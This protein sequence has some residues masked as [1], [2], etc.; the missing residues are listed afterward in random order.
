MT[1][2]HQLYEAHEAKTFSKKG[3]EIDK[4]VYSNYEGE[5]E[6]GLEREFLCFLL[7]LC[8]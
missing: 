6:E 8:M 2:R 3:E 7:G 4:E 1:A 5:L